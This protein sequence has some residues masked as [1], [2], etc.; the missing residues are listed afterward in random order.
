MRAEGSYRQQTVNQTTSEDAQTWKKPFH[1]MSPTCNPCTL[2]QIN[3]RP[4]LTWC[5]A[6]GECRDRPVRGCGGYELIA[7]VREGGIEIRLNR[8]SARFHVPGTVLEL[9]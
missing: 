4:E 8:E 9:C 3:L 5:A 1:P 6:C 7:T 2:I